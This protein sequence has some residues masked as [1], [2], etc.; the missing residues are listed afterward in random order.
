M[1]KNRHTKKQDR[2]QEQFLSEEEHHRRLWLQYVLQT[3]MP[4][5]RQ[6]PSSKNLKKNSYG[7]DS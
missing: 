1:K 6:A 3:P 5:P 7:T 2:D 4:W